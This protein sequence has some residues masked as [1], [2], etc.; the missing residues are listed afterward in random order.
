[1]GCTRPC[2]SLSSQ[3][4]EQCCAMWACMHRDTCTCECGLGDYLSLTRS[5]IA[6][7]DSSPPLQLPP[8]STSLSACVCY[9]LPMLGVFADD[10]MCF[11][12]L[13]GLGAVQNG[14]IAPIGSCCSISGSARRGC[15]IRLLLDTLC[16]LQ[17]G[18]EGARRDGDAESAHKPKACSKAARWPRTEARL[19]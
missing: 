6:S 5:L 7:L 15:A 18:R 19:P 2:P 1:M 14:I 16:D 12:G 10:E 17:I 8:L 13:C 11:A 9:Y 4:S 3:Q